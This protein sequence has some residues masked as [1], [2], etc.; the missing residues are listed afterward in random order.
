MN[1]KT[2][3]SILSSDLFYNSLLILIVL[4][5]F[6][7]LFFPYQQTFITPDV[8][9]SDQIHFNYAQK[10][11]LSNALQ[12]NQF[13]W[14]S[15]MIANGYP[16]IGESQ[17]GAFYLPNIILFKLF[18]F[19][20]AFNLGYV[21]SFCL[22]SLG[23]Y[24]Y[25]LQ[26]TSKKYL[27]FY[28]SLILAFSAPF[29]IHVV[30][31]NLL[32]TYSLVPLLLLCT[33]KIITSKNKRLWSIVYTLIN[34]QQF[35]AGYVM[36][37][38]VTNILTFIYIYMRL[39]FLNYRKV[40]RYLHYSLIW[41]GANIATFIISAIQLIPMLE[42]AK[43]ST[44]ILGLGAEALDNSFYPLLFRTFLS[45]YPFQNPNVGSFEKSV[46]VYLSNKV[47]DGNAYY[48][49]LFFCISLF[50]IIFFLKSKRIKFFAVLALI[51]FFFALGKNSP[52]YFIYLFPI[53]NFFR[54]PSRFV[55]FMDLFLIAGTVITLEYILTVK[56]KYIS[57]II[58]LLTVIQIILLIIGF[59]NYHPLDTFHN[60]ESK[61]IVSEI[62]GGTQDSKRIYQLGNEFVWALNMYYDGWKDPK[63]YEFLMND[64]NT[65]FNSVFSIPSANL[66]SGSFYY[67]QR[68]Y[69]VD[70]LIQEQFLKRLFSIDE[71]K[72]VFRP[73]YRDKIL[74]L[75]FTKQL[76]VDPL[77]IKTLQMKGVHYVISPFN[78]E[79]N[80]SIHKVSEISYRSHI[81]NYLRIYKVENS[82]RM[83]YATSH[84][85]Q[86][87]TLTEI[88]NK[89]KSSKH[90]DE[91]FLTK[92]Y[93]NKLNF[94]QGYSNENIK[95][96][97]LK[98]SAKK[99]D[100]LTDSTQ[101]AFIASTLSYY[102]GWK[103]KI[104]NKPSDI[105]LIN[106]NQI[107]MQV[108]SGEHRITLQYSPDWYLAS[109]TVTISGYICLV[110][111]MVY[112]FVY[113]AH[114]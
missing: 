9:L 73:E 2:I 3:Q 8:A 51:C 62:N 14:W 76:T 7:H 18:S 15:N 85:T 80:P 50:G 37:S 56:N 42:F 109:M 31:Y 101:K 17:I 96:K 110:I 45:L 74:K 68:Y 46:Y 24:Y 102:Q 33:E 10:K 43:N 86:V 65:Y 94:P 44:R 29:F 16:L 90:D 75:I 30:H 113:R 57:L 25:L 60:I 92:S 5:P 84:L 71:I 32:Q 19:S 1:K 11:I 100:L 70:Q 106:I 78:L 98:Y 103:V 88:I 58:H 20:L 93:V 48:G 91:I 36:I 6:V 77:F 63:L 82:R 26:F 27:A 53:F 28:G 112:Y 55:F 54:T 72:D 81:I 99:I 83:F 52:F 67:P 38:F 64:L 79:P 35:L 39:Y 49:L 47:W 40:I 41:I 22:V 13:P 59:V 21:F 12:E 104:D 97:I 69:I 108:P 114:D 34:S 23:M 61:P 105:F 107:G 66:F 111:L 89:L 95:I 4:I 87:A